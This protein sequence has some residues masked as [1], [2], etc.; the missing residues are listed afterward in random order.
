MLPRLNIIVEK[1]DLIT[2]KAYGIKQ[3]RQFLAGRNLVRVK[4]L[5]L[6]LI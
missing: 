2:V 4:Y 3:S 1:T 6:C 5:I